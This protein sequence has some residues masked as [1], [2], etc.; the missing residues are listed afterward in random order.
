MSGAGRRALVVGLGRSGRAAAAL[1]ARRGWDVVAVDAGDA[2]APELTAAGVDV[3]AP[4]SGAVPGVELVVKSPGVPGEAAPVAAAR[5]AGVPVWSEVELASRELDNLLIGVTGTNGKTTTTELTAHLL[6][7]SGIA[8][9]ACG[10]QG[11]PIA[12]LVE[13]VDPA[14][15]LVVEC[16]SFQLED[17]HSLHPAA[18]VLL[19]LAPDH[20][21]RH[22][23]FEEYRSAKLRLFRN[24]SAGDLAIL[25]AG[26]APA[27]AVAARTVELGAATPAAV[28]WGQGGVHVAGLGRVTGW[29]D[30]LLRG[31]HNRHNVLVAA[32]LAAHAGAGAAGIAAGLASFA[33]VAHRLEPVGSAEGVLYVND[34]KATNPDAA[35]AALG[36]YGSGVHLI[37]GGRGKD[38][39]FDALAEI[40]RGA[41]VHAYVV[42]ET[43]PQLAAA[44]RRVG[45]PCQEA[46]TVEAAVV[47][48]AG[49]ARAGEV[50]LLAPA[51]ASFDQFADYGERG[52]AFRAAARA[53]GAR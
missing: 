52:D 20:L 3:R 10:N 15:W 34:S 11:D 33:P 32:A 4:H 38:T 22:A 51:C 29:D 43:G 5:A 53:A 37:A 49:R 48:A 39:P 18:A 35:A 46:G 16:S 28:A 40:A 42:G 27:A 24:Q 1:L 7:A 44:F 17:A 45:V 12:G 19:N 13:A 50:V 30:V 26:M 2:E 36:A 23:S 47:A 8:A 31:D 6:R 9:R 41:C 25:P 14:E 21:D